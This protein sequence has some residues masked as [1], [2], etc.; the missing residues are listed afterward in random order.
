MAVRLGT[1]G[2][3]SDYENWALHVAADWREGVGKLAEDAAGYLFGEIESRV[4][5]QLIIPAALGCSH[6][7]IPSYLLAPPA[8]P[9]E[10]P[11]YMPT[12]ITTYSEQ[13]IGGAG[14]PLRVSIPAVVF[15]TTSESPSEPPNITGI[16]IYA[17][18]PTGVEVTVAFHANSAGVPGAIANNA[19][20]VPVVSGTFT[21]TTAENFRPGF[22]WYYLELGSAYVYPVP[23][24]ILYHWV[25]YPTVST[26]TIRVALGEDFSGGNSYTYNGS[27]WSI[28]TGCPLFTYDRPFPG[29]SSSAGV[30]PAGIFGMMTE[31]DTGEIVSVIHVVGASSGTIFQTI[32][33]RYDANENVW[34]TTDAITATAGSLASTVGYPVLFGG[35]AYIP[36]GINFAV[37]TLATDG[38]TISSDDANLFHS[39][40]GYLWRAYA[41]RL[42]YS[43]D[44]TTWTEIEGGVGPNDYLIRGLAGLGANMYVSTD[45]ALYYVAPGDAVVGVFPWGTISEENGRGMI[46][47]QGAVYIPAAGRL[48]KF[49]EDGS[50][51]DIWVNRD[52]DLN[53]RRLG[54]IAALASLNNAL[55]CGVNGTTSDDPS[56]VW[57]YTGLG[58]H[59][60]AT[61]PGGFDIRSLYYDRVRSRL[62]IASDEWA[63]FYIHAP[64]WALNPYNDSASV[65]MPV[66]WVETDR[67]FAG[68][69]DL[70]KDVEDMRLFG[71]FGA[72]T[73]VAVYWQDQDS[74]DWELLGEFNADG[75]EVRWADTTTRPSTRWIRIGLLFQTTDPTQTTRL[76]AW[77]LKVMPMVRDR[78][79]WD[80]TINVADNQQMIG[81]EMN[82]RYADEMRDHLESLIESVAP[83]LFED[84]DGRQYWVKIMGA[85][86]SLD[87][88]EN[89]GYG[90]V[91]WSMKFNM[92]LEQIESVF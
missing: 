2:E 73:S 12:D 62:W 13:S 22:K 34:N 60:L 57:A 52:D 6:I 7:V 69:R 29:Y 78:W 43:A 27:T 71:E 8:E 46:A 14:N 31:T 36:R 81:G 51:Q 18:I 53:A 20:S 77:V 91:R 59:H 88:Y 50:T 67:I 86:E 58:W 25:V 30:V 80:F 37:W 1:G 47:H 39:W 26:N 85:G 10:R 32:P 87:N 3:F 17:D 83:V 40:S 38:L 55:V 61:L 33:I 21:P 84:V 11:Y 28:N 74:T 23:G 45:E 90:D 75:E 92:S 4:P 54:N 44:A 49:T 19:G 42:W 24:N 79:R 65:Y 68:S 64:D 76:R 5:E 35:S 89:D 48:W 56:S 72:D 9:D 63:V 82:D 15:S 66:G 16:A 70:L 41:N